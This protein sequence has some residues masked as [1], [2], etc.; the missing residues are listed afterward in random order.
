MKD[1]GQGFDKIRAGVFAWLTRFPFNRSCATISCNA[2]PPPSP[3]PHPSLKTEILPHLSCWIGF[4]S[5]QYNVMTSC[6]LSLLQNHLEWIDFVPCQN[7]FPTINSHNWVQ[8][9][10]A[11]KSIAYQEYQESELVVGCKIFNESQKNYI[12]SMKSNLAKAIDVHL[13][14]SLLSSSFWFS[15]K[16]S[17]NKL[18]FGKLPVCIVSSKIWARNLLEKKVVG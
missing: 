8:Y 4:D 15:Q 3:P 1:L 18:N 9:S 7:I 11:S 13:I 2:Q 14:C 10:R 12:K 16:H 6:E 17:W 5:I